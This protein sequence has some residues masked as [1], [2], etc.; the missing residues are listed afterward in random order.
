MSS[1]KDF[2]ERLKTDEDFLKLIVQKVNAA[3]DKGEKDYKKIIIPIAAEEGYELSE[4]ELDSLY[5]TGSAELSEEELGKVAGGTS[6]LFLIAS[7]FLSTGS[8][9]ISLETV[10]VTLH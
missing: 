5:E 3:S 7:V 6:P 9:L 4:D 10:S 8:V 1:T 2:I